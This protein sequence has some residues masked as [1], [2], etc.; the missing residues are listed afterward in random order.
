MPG[1]KYFPGILHYFVGVKL[2]TSSIRVNLGMQGHL[3]MFTDVKAYTRGSKGL[4]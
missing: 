2:G 1:L 3:K 4:G